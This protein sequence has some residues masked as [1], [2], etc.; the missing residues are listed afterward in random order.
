[1]QPIDRFFSVA[2]VAVLLMESTGAVIARAG[3]L[4]AGRE[5]NAIACLV[6]E[7]HTSREPAVT[8]VVFHHR[9][10]ADAARLG[11]LLRE[12]SG[13]VVE[14]QT[15]DGEWRKATAVRLK[16]CFGRGL[17]LFPAGTPQLKEGDE[18]LLKFPSSE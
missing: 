1:M 16:S 8:V 17:L 6:M 2:L 9:E 12:R 5:A 14:I 15:A 18:F 7:V 10:K 4:S 3:R 13:A 11:A